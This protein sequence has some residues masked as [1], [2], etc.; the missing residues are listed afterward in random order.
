MSENTQP[1]SASRIVV[2]STGGT[3]ACTTDPDG[4]LNPT[5]SG[6][7]LCA[8]VL[9]TL[10]ADSIT[11]TVRELGCRDSASLRLADVDEIIAATH[12]ELNDP[13]VTGVV[14]T[15][16]TD[17]MEETAI[18]LDVF[19]DDARPVVLTGAQLPCDHPQSDGQQNLR[20]ALIVAA[21]PS[22]RGIGVLIV[23]G[24]AV[25]PA[26]GATKWN[27]TDTLAFATNGPEEPTRPQPLPIV[28]L[29][30]TR[31]DIISAY[32]GAPR[33]LVDDARHRG[34]QGI[35]I[36]GMGAGNVGA[37]IAAA[38]KD[39]IAAGIPVVMT[40]RVSRGDV[41]GVY[42]G[43]GGGATLARSGAVGSRY[44]RAPQSRIL[45]AAAIAAGVHPTTLF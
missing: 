21:D 42:G 45:L 22:A 13:S 16:G 2:I 40:T 14:I 7:E 29:A 38:I 28:P 39:T 26:R 19:H 4:S 12:E 25:I 8:P 20:E 35:V 32:P 36:E 33:E 6:E 10:P 24:H 37:D 3:I 23:F 15:H 27:T 34:A 30:N 18:A 5:V 43:A 31:V 17:S 44:F 41:V 11:V 1:P 9:K